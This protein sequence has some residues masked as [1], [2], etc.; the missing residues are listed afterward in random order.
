MQGV[1]EFLSYLRSLDVHLSADNGQLSCNAPKGVLTV[2]LREQIRANKFQI[3]AFLSSHSQKNE[4]APIARVSREGFP[5]PS[6][7]QERL[8]FLDQFEGESSAYNLAA[9]LRLRGSLNRRALANSWKE[10][11]RRHEVLRTGIVGVDG[12]PK[13]VIHTCA[14]WEMDIRSFRDMPKQ[15]QE[16]A[17]LKFAQTELSR[18]YDLSAPPAIRVCLIELG[19]QDHVLLFGVHH[20]VADGWSLGIITTELT[21]LYTAICEGGASPLPELPIQYLDYAHWHR[22]LLRNGTARAQMDYWKKQLAGSIPVL[23][24]RSDRPRQSTLSNHGKRAHLILSEE[25]LAAAKKLSLAEDATLFSTC[26][27]VFKI[28]VHRYTREADIIVG[29]VA[30]GRTRPELEPL[31]GLFLNNLP[32]RA[33]LSGDPT[34]RELLAQVRENSLNAFSNQD[35]PFSDLVE[36]TQAPRDLN[37]SPLFQVMFI[38]QNFPLRNVQ[39]PGLEV[40][41]LEF[42]MG[43]SRFDLTVEAGERDQQ[44]HM[45]W[46]YNADLFEAS[47]IRR[48]QEHY[49]SLL[50]SAVA[51]PD[52]NISALEMMTAEERETLVA[53]AAGE[54]IGVPRETC[55]HD[56]FGQQV[57]RNPEALALA[58]EGEELTYAELNARSNRLANRLR[59]LNVGPDVL[60][61]IC[62]ERSAEIAVAVLAVLKAGGAYVPVDPQYPRDRVAFMLEDSQAAVLITEERLL[63]GLPGNVPSV[64]CLDRDRESLARESGEL[65]AGGVAPENLAYVIYTSGSTGKPKGVEVTHRSVV[66]FLT[67]L[68]REP[69]VSETDRLLAVTTLS[70]DIAGLEIYL[71]LTTGASVVVAPQAALVDGASLSRLL[72]ERKITVMQATPVTWRLLLDSG[73]NPAPGFKVLC[74]GEALPRELANRLMATGAEVWNLYGPTETTIWSTIHRADSRPGS[75]PIGK[76]IANTQVYI[77]DERRRL[78]PRGVPGELYIGGDGL[79]RGYLRRPELTAERFVPNPFGSGGKLY[80][81]GDLV[82]WLSDGSLEYVGR[83]DHQVK[84]RGFRIELGEIETALEAQ[85]QVRQAVVLVRED[86]PDDQRLTAYVTLHDNASADAKALR[87]SLSSRLPDYMLPSQWVFLKEFPLT[88]NRKIDRR[89]LPVPA[90]DEPKSALSAPPTTESEIKVAAIWQDLLKHKNVGVNDNFFDLGGHSLL[91]VQLQSRLRKQLDCQISLVELFQRTTVSSIASYLDAQKR[92]SKVLDPVSR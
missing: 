22:E 48:M 27:A 53:A 57:A 6:L 43:S 16:A 55:I 37:R 56:L 73:W 5:A 40:D 13:A 21:Q 65:P 8:W 35:V 41:L 88:P 82:R 59:A 17:V 25:I 14:E 4:S 7:Q 46:E 12:R 74:G 15:D 18:P 31:V 62:L 66:N 81:T 51:N 71:P 91:V 60:V 1:V 58:F 63:G 24:L 90:N 64:I 36:A 75:V 49:R 26:L 29:S 10:I 86:A 28:L 9:G 78:V 32:I 2:E 61:G 30:A 23:D 45:L 38:L 76:P 89:A 70:F 19:E 52:A 85:P 77:L 79:A 54:R 33:D 84:L 34:F 80:R 42:D 67:S 11:I 69:G 3:I 92:N 44:L 68:R 50:E 47:T 39:L 87:A 83:I 72:R 20:I